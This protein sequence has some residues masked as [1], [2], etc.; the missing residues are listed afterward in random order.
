MTRLYD[1]LRRKTNAGGFLPQIDGLRFLAIMPVVIAHLNVFV[2]AKAALMLAPG[3][4]SYWLSG[5]INNSARQGVMLFFII[6]GFILVTPFAKQFLYGGKT[7]VLKDYFLRRVTRLEPPY[8]INNILYAILVVFFA[9]HGY[10]S[11]FPDGTVLKHLGASLLYIH[12]I[13][14][15]GYPALNYV[16][17]SLEVEIQFYL[18]VPLLVLLFKL[19]T[20]FRRAFL[21][22]LIFVFPVL[23][24]FYIPSFISLYNFIQY[25]LIGFFVADLY[26]S[27]FTIKLNVIVDFLIG[28]CAVAS[29]FYIDIQKAVLLEYIFMVL[30]LIFS[31]LALT[32]NFWKKVLSIRVI[33]T[34]GGMCYSIYLW[35]TAIISGI[36]NHFILIGGYHY[37]PIALL[38]QT[39]IIVPILLVL[40]T[41]FYVL[42][43]Q[44]CMDRN[45]SSKL[46][47]Y[48]YER[49]L[50]IKVA[51]MK[52]I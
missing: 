2:V 26:L 17:W 46:F 20:F 1:R 43:E 9:S 16:T 38:L 10:A 23:Q 50:A 45:W 19:P 15:S 29:I 36:G 33:T 24:H 48:V 41:I 40:T 44:P 30:M 12:N 39:I 47:R 32:G 34:I 6:S 4:F 8:I 3:S 27:G 18:L 22:S 21:L 49:F 37:Y 28:L 11:L 52:F 25:F 14:Y 31:L 13:V 5:V 7:I 42:I 35:H 51:F